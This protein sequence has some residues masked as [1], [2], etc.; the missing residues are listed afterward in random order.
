[1]DTLAKR[2]L[3]ARTNKFRFISQRQLADKA[4]VSSQTICNIENGHSTHPSGIDKIADALGVQIKWLRDGVGEI[5]ITPIATDILDTDQLKKVLVSCMKINSQKRYFV[6]EDKLAD[7]VIAVYKTNIASTG[8][9][10]KNKLIA[11]VE[12]ALTYAKGIG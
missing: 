11:S 1:M 3:Y 4:D 6:S 7:A 10:D 5:D 8:G 2:L 12:T 9:F